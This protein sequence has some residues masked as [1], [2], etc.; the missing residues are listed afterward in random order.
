M[1]TFGFAAVGGCHPSIPGRCSLAS[2]RMT[3]SVQGW[4]AVRRVLKAV[5]PF[6]WAALLF[7]AIGSAFLQGLLTSA[8]GLVWTGQVVHGS[9]AAGVL[10][11][12]YNGRSFSYEVPGSYRTGPVTVYVDPSDPSSYTLGG[13]VERVSGAAS[14]LGPYAV[15]VAVFVGGSWRRRRNNRRHLEALNAH[16]EFGWGINPV[17]IERMLQEKRGEQ[18]PGSSSKA[19]RLP[20]GDD[21]V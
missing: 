10:S 4:R 19:Q 21:R 12:T 7:V 14:V 13:A 3:G 5:P 1:S 9:E 17:V 8:A 18:P 2:N 11:Y 20:P 6:G 15:A 16:K